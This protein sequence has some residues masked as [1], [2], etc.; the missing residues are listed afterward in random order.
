MLFVK[1]HGIEITEKVLSTTFLGAGRNL[2]I[3]I[4]S[5][6]SWSRGDLKSTGW[7]GDY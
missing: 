6:L 7:E 4:H 3:C 2:V 1:N 5:L